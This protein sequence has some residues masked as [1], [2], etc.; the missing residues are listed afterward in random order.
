VFAIGP[1]G[2][3]LFG[4]AGGD[5]EE[6]VD[7]EGPDGPGRRGPIRDLKLIAGVPYAV[8][9]SRQVYRRDGAYN[10]THQDEGTLAPKGVVTL[11]GFNA[12]DGPA[13]SCIYAV[14][15]NGEIWR[16]LNGGWQ[17]LDSPTTLGLH[18]RP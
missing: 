13:E 14:G 18:S 12:L 6:H 4:T 1:D 7:G 3:I 17:Q 11:S 10:W 15:F 5:V 9:M 8:G 2:I 16:R